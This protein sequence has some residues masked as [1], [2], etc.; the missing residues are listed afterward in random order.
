M[1][2]AKEFPL[3]IPPHVA[4]A[5]ALAGSCSSDWTPRL[6]PSICRGFGAKKQKNPSPSSL[7]GCYVRSESALG[8]GFVQDSPRLC[9]GCRFGNNGVLEGGRKANIQRFVIHQTFAERHT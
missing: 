2:L 5:V 3:K 6:G 1:M 4:V 7:A 9:A 8:A